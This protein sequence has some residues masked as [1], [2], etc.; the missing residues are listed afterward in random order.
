[1]GELID[2]KDKI[3]RFY[4]FSPSEIG[5]LIFSII[6]I[7]FIISFKDWGVGNVFNLAFGLVN[8]FN[9]ILIVTLSLLVRDAVQKIW[10]LV[11]G[12]RIEFK[13]WTFGL[14]F[15]LGLAFLSN[16]SLWLIV[17]GGFIIH[18]LPGHR[19]G[20][21]RYGLNYFAQAMIALS[22]PL[23]LLTL[24]IFF[25]IIGLFTM[26]ALIQKAI[27]FNVIFIL[28][29]LLPI[30]PLDGSKIM[31]GSRMLYAFMTPTLIAATILLISNVNVFLAI[32]LS[33][34]LGFILWVTYYIAFERNY[35]SG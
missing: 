16:G 23:A 24:I 6:V 19:L 3:K 11:V 13:M 21:F 22:G 35:W 33:L 18:H 25:K 9:A 27:M 29:S 17:P 2:L 4:K 5:G 26:N 32:F 30:P 12:Y 31:W 14:L 10:A 1:M 34:A 15:A 28:T 20:W 7:A 8:F